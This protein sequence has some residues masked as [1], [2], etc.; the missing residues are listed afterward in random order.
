[1]P[2]SKKSVAQP[3]GQVVRVTDLELTEFCESLSD[4][5]LDRLQSAATYEHMKRIL[6]P[7]PDLDA[8]L[9]ELANVDPFCDCHCPKVG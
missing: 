6:A 8:L 3:P 7:D 5:D 9:E 4:E 1:M 2:K